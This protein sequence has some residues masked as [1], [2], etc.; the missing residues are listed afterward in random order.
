MKKIIIISLSI[1]LFSSCHF[2]SDYQDQAEIVNGI[3]DYRN[4]PDN[5]IVALDGEWKFIDKHVNPTF[6]DWDSIK[7]PKIWKN[8]ISDGTYQLEILIPAE[9]KAYGI[10]IRDCYTSYSLIINGFEYIN[11]NIGSD[12]SPSIEP[13]TYHITAQDKI[14]ITLAVSDYHTTFGGINSSIYF[15]SPSRIKIMFLRRIF[16]DVLITGALLFAGIFYLIIWYINKKGNGKMYLFLFT[17]NTF[18]GIRFLTT[19]NRILL[20]FWNNFVIVETI[21]SISTPIICLFYSLYFLNIYRYP[22]YSKIVKMFVAVTVAYIC[23]ILFT[24][25]LFIYYISSIYVAAMIIAMYSTI[26][27][28]FI[29]SRGLKNKTF[30]LAWSIVMFT[31]I[32]MMY[33]AL[34]IWGG[35]KSSQIHIVYG[36]ISLLQGFQNSLNYG[37]TFKRNAD[38]VKQKNDFFTQITHSLRTPLYGIRGSLELIVRNKNPFDEFKQ[39]F[40]IIDRSVTDLTIQINDLLSLTEFEFSHQIIKTQSVLET[41]IQTILIVDDEWINCQIFKDQLK[42]IID[43]P[44]IITVESAQKALFILK[45]NDIGII[46]TDLRMPEIDGLEFISICREKGYTQPIYL[47]SA[48]TDKE[49]KQKA[50]EAGANGFIPKPPSME[51][52]Q[53][54]TGFH[55]LQKSTK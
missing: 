48:S 3:L 2:S 31:L 55:L 20:H 39:K 35:M 44:K 47:F 6:E 50:L 30:F 25:M 17:T 28:S 46:F 4:I 8:K 33:R 49:N 32:F 54:V 42:S 29:H 13:R 34:L 18:M 27:V 1:L 16:V 24:P 22:I 51:T 23:F 36:I 19:Y 11:G 45:T 15:G 7:V 14:T 41:T 38:L 10:Y 52:L 21:S 26:H 40:N 43:N 5:E 37:E 53:N 9:T 12:Y